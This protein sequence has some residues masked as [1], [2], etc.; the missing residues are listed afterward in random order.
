MPDS[1]NGRILLV[2]DDV[3]AAEGVALALESRGYSVD[4][5]EDGDI[6]LDLAEEQI[7][8]VVLSDIRMPM[9]DG[10]EL[11]DALRTRR[12][13]L[14][15]VLMTAFDSAGRAIEATKRGAFDYL[16]K[17]FRMEE[18]F[19][20]LDKAIATNRLTAKRV[21]V[22]G[23]ADD[24][25]TDA[26]CMVGSCAGMREV[27]KAIGR[28][29]DKPV[30]VLVKGETGTGKE[31]V[32][33]ALYSHGRR[34]D[35]PF[36]AVNC[37]AIPE[38]LIESEL[39]GHERGAFTGATA[40]R[41]GRFEQAD[42]GM[43]FLDEVGDLRPATQVKLLRVLQERKITRVG[44]TEAL[45]IDVVV[46]SATHRD[47]EKM[48]ADGEFREDL[49][50]RL[51]AAV[52][53]LPP[54]R[55]RLADI[56]PLAEHFFLQYAQEF[57]YGEAG[58]AKEAI[59]ALERS[60]WPGNVREL[61]NVIRK[62]LVDA[63]GLTVTAEH[64]RDALRDSPGAKV[65]AAAGE[66]ADRAGGGAVGDVEA[67]VLAAHIRKRLEE[68]AASASGGALAALIDEVEAIIYAEALEISFGNQSQVSK[69][70]GVSR[71]T[72]REKLDRF[73]L[74]PN[75]GKGG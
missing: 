53:Q 28:L 65:K 18:L 31:L 64:V 21:V 58:L 75:R 47:I 46:I 24:A 6:A 41:I 14:P 23:N 56:A 40:R 37:A 16:A 10:L 63:H 48:I 8:D 26:D 3:K 55:E 61:E 25:D 29:A 54:L 49:Y 45:P 5:A 11:L 39:F 50:Y 74:F 27:F 42:G 30:S 34:S 13:R 69:L 22:P 68:R 67:D 66:A 60:S 70:L 62:S 19:E 43:L 33:R 72:V 38:N 59:E 15:V 35:G 20:V 73:S 44:G 36:I 17:P 7:F 51:A 32:A 9:M 4:H 71:S 12:P 52:I 2:D 1:N 57:G